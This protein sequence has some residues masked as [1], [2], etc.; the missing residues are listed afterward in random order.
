M[1]AVTT[2]DVVRADPGTEG[3]GVPARSGSRT[4]RIG[5][6]IVAAALVVAAWNAPV[7]EARLTAPQYPQGLRLTAY[8][9]RVNG[10]IREINDLNHYVGMKAFTIEDVPEH[11]LWPLAIVGGLLAI[12]IGTFVRG[13]FGRLARIALWAIPL[14]VL[15]DVQLRL[16]QYGHS[17][18]PKAAI[19]LDPFTP[20]V[21][22]PTK[23]VNFTTWSYPGL[24]VGL[25]LGAAMLVT[26]GPGLVSR[27]GG[28]PSDTSPE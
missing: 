12:A 20:L 1:S 22:G 27:L 5:L 15:A 14:G 8:A 2:T 13:W 19:R 25:L 4:I 9:D 24:A 23:V 10:D 28:R 3:A 7:W 11:V 16:M 17:V 21:I 18:D 6:G 26:F